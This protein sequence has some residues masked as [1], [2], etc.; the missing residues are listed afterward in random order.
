MRLEAMDDKGA[1]KGCEL[2]GGILGK[3]LGSNFVCQILHT[4]TP[5]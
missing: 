5:T 2:C 3:I 1:R 4:L